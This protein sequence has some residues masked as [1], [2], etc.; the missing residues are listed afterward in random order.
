MLT[1]TSVF[2]SALLALALSACSKAPDSPEPSPAP[3]SATSEDVSVDD[4]NQGG[5]AV[6]IHARLQY[7]SQTSTPK[8]SSNY[9]LDSAFYLATDAL[10]YDDGGTISYTMQDS[11]KVQG[12]LNAQGSAHIVSDDMVA[13]ETYQMQGGWP[14]VTS[15][16]LPQ[17][18]I[19]SVEPSHIGEGMSVTVE[20]AVPVKG[21]KKSL[22]Q[23][24]DSKIENTEIKFSA[25]LEC[26]AENTHDDICR[27]LFTIDAVPS[28]ARDAIGEQL[29]ATAKDLYARQGKIGSDDSL[30]LF[31]SLVPVYGA[32]TS[33][34]GE[35]F[36]TQLDQHYEVTQKETQLAQ[37]LK[38]V[39]WSTPRGELNEPEA[40]KRMTE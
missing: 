32:T 35:H 39:V 4:S 16:D 21:I 15:V 6:T 20:L 18:R 17:L 34:T 24:K 7:S 12:Q 5:S 40:A 25:P 2:T 36:V 30:V 33:Q 3:E 1:R 8:L 26:T 29:L 31:S 23:N 19:K 22:L 10:R 11:N 38:V 27:L 28:E 13:D 37:H 14:E 9:K